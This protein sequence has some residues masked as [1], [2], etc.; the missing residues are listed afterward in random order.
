MAEKTINLNDL[1]YGILPFRRTKPATGYCLFLL[2]SRRESSSAC[3]LEVS[4]KIESRLMST[5]KRKD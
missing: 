1:D 2:C 4:S 5:I 3:L